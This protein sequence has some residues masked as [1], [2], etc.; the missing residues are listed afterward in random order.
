MRPR[1]TEREQFSQNSE[2]QNWIYKEKGKYYQDKVMNTPSS[3]T[4]KIKLKWKSKAEVL[5][6]LDLIK[7]ANLR[8]EEA[9]GHFFGVCRDIFTIFSGVTY[10]LVLERDLP[11]QYTYRADVVDDGQ[12]IMA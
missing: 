2:H 7:T 10:S 3:R 11:A 4:E 5:T 12:F 1:Y 9:K 8:E 6:L